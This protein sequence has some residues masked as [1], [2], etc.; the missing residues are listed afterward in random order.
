MRDANGRPLGSR[1][2]IMK[3]RK[4]V[5]VRRHFQ[6]ERGN[7]KGPIGDELRVTCCVCGTVTQRSLA[8]MNRYGRTQKQMNRKVTPLTDAAV[9]FKLSYWKTRTDR[10]HEFSGGVRG[11]CKTCTKIARDKLYPLPKRKKEKGR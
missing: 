6:I 5:K 3:A 11:V 1:A 9:E 7:G 8:M 2:A 4:K 10:P